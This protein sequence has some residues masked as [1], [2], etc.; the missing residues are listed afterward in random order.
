MVNEQRQWQLLNELNFTRVSGSKEEKQAAEILKENAINAKAENATIETF[1]VDGQTVKH[2][3]LT[4]DK[5]DYEVSAYYQ[6][7]NTPSEGLTAPFYYCSAM[8]SDVALQNCEGKIVLVNG[9]M[10]FRTYEKLI[11]GKA[12]GFITF[13]GDLRDETTDLKHRELR[14]ILRE[15]GNI[16]GVHMSI[17]NAMKLVL[18]NPDT[19]T[20][21]TAQ[22]TYKISSQNVICEIEGSKYPDQVI[23][24]TAHY[25]SVEYSKGVYDNGAG[26]VILSELLYHFMENKPDRTL[27]FIWCGSEERGLLGSKAYCKDHKEDLAKVVFNVNVDV[28]GPVLGKDTAA[29]TGPESCVHYIEYMA[30]EIGAEIVVKQDIY[31]SDC[32][33]FADNG[34]P[35]V[36][37]CRFGGPGMAYIHNRYDQ[38]FFMDSKNLIKTTEFVRYFTERV[39]NAYTFPIPREMPE[40]MVK[41]VDE[42]LFKN[43]NKKA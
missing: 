38:L 9:Y 8:E 34:I 14:S 39:A 42:Y 31:S 40:N 24:L 4:T 26:S 3:S 12:V 22:D 16:P 18:E 10:N 36:S 29:V 19:I 1:E 25:D 15:Q 33:P 32:I 6:C 35:A 41:K 23:T 27:R 20:M 5:N 17:Q 43:K 21:K 11:K 37:F 13:D 7:A 2:A 28:A 30:R